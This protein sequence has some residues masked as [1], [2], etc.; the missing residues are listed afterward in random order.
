VTRG[1]HRK[2]HNLSQAIQSIEIFWTKLSF[3]GQ[4]KSN[5][6]LRHDARWENLLDAGMAMRDALLMSV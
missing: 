3:F 5:N 6:D 4:S 2:S 1:H